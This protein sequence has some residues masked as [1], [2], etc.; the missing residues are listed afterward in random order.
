MNIMKLRVLWYAI[1]GAL[2]IGSIVAIGMFGLRQGIDFTGGSLMALRFE[3]RPSSLDVGNVLSEMSLGAV[4]GQPVGEQDM[5]LRM[6]TLTEEEHTAVLDRLST[7]FG[8]VQELRYDAIG[9]SIGAELRA[10]SWKALLVVFVGILAYVAY[11]FRKVSAPIASWKYGI[12]TIGTALHDVI[13]PLGLFAI[14]GHF[15]QVEIGTPFIAAI[16]TIMGYS[17]NDTII[18]F[19]RVRENLQRMGGSFDE[20]VHTSLK[21]TYARSL[22]TSLT[23]LFT[24]VAIYLFGGDSIKEFALALIV[25]ILAGTYSSIFVAAPMLVTWDRFRRRK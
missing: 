11:M 18:V 15:G 12:I 8:T 3:E 24:L 20:I 9:P 2:V 17:I 21:Q 25:G 23:T 5:N 13:I 22:Y 19:D 6:K 1:S 16:L 10:K 4:V 7:A 14:L